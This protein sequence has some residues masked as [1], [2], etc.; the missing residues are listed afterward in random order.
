MRS[1]HRLGGPAVLFLI[2]TCA[3]GRFYADSPS[4]A[5]SSIRQAQLRFVKNYVTAVQSRD[6][7]KVLQTFHPAYRACVNSENKEYFDQDISRRMR[8]VPGTGYKVASLQPAD[9]KQTFGAAFLPADGFEYPAKPAYVVQVDFESTNGG[10]S[11]YSMLL[12][13]APDH[14][15]WYWFGPCL[16]AKGLEFIRQRMQEGERQ[17][18]EARK[19]VSELKDPLLSDL[20]HLLKAHDR[21]GAIKTYRKETGAELT[22]A[23]Q[24]ID[25]LEEAEGR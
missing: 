4:S 11:S 8:Y 22:T 7:Q 17:R 15:S 19:R 2:V 23:V 18:A 16:N 21:M 13:I 3:T 25:E 6:A 10:T 14:G 5:A 12:E 24:V 20:K 1:R 9:P